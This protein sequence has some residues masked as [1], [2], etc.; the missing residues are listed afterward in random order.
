MAS[1]TFRSAYWILTIIV[2]TAYTGNLVA[3]MSVTK[4]QLPVDSLEELTDHP[5]Y[6]AGLIIG[7]STYNIF[8]VDT[9]LFP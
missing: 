8:K 9:P 6:Q 2:L 7:S 4:L 3:Y 5:E 1:R